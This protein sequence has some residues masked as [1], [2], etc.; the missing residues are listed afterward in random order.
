MNT[1]FI[2][3]SFYGNSF[4]FQQLS[5]YSRNTEVE[6]RF[7]TQS[8]NGV[9]LIAAGQ[10]NYLLIR[11]SEGAIEVGYIPDQ[12]CSDLMIFNCLFRYA[13]CLKYI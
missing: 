5:S 7:Q 6:L 4:L 2:S 8:P 13:K 9:I 10:T 3:A 1:S 12:I 11:L